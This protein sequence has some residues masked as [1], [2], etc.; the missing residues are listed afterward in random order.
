MKE[1]RGSWYLLT[2]VILGVGLGL[3][4]AWAIS[5]ARVTNVVPENLAPEY[6]DDYRVAIASAYLATGDLSR[7]KARLQL[8][9]DEDPAQLLAAQ[10]QRYLA[11]G[12]PYIE[13]EALAALAAALEQNDNSEPA[14]VTA[15]EANPSRPTASPSPTE[16]ASPTPSEAVSPSVTEASA[17]ESETPGPSETPEPTTTRTPSPSPTPSETPEVTFTPV[18]TNTLT[19]TLLPPLVFSDQTLVCDPLITEAQLRI[20]VNDKSGRGIAGVEVII[21]DDGNEEHFFTGLKPDIDQ[22]YADYT[23]QPGVEYSLQV[24][25]GGEP[26]TITAEECSQDEGEDYWGSWR[27]TFTTP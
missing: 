14:P 20:Y 18:P 12:R 21:Q 1:Q 22:G 9:H 26:I 13:A 25:K 23:L 16:Q 2:G 8:L 19:P 15:T 27:L 24:G 11:A 5:P 10:S 6:K 7:A 17:S 3:L 4:Y